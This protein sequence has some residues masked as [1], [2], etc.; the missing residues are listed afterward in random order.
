MTQLQSGVSPTLAQIRGHLYPQNTLSFWQS[1]KESF[2]RLASE[3]RIRELI[4][5]GDARCVSALNRPD[6]YTGEDLPDRPVEPFTGPFYADFDGKE[7]RLETVIKDVQCFGHKLERI[8]LDPDQVRWYVSG[9]KGFHA[10]VSPLCIVE[11]GRVGSPLLPLIYRE[12]ALGL[13]V[14]TLDMAVYSKSKGR[15]WRTPNVK[16]ENGNYKIPVTWTEI[17]TMTSVEYG[18]LCSGP[19]PYPLIVSPTV[20]NGL[21]AMYSSATDKVRGKQRQKKQKSVVIKLSGERLP[22]SLD[23]LLTGRISSNIGFNKIAI[24][25]ATLAVSAGWSSSDLVSRCRGLIDG[26]QS[27]GRYCTP[28]LREAELRRLYGYVSGP[29]G[30]PFSLAGLRSLFPH[31]IKT[32]DLNA[33]TGGARHG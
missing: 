31:G 20:C 2:W 30:Y 15:M 21:A 14:D 24:Q 18:H 5:S 6:T 28:L 33:L 29:G 23:A 22:P 7:G 17:L 3:T 16:R 4:D 19:R 26:H 9:G 25:L 27:D 10:E 11:S 32:S 13:V 1:C 8:G 12:M